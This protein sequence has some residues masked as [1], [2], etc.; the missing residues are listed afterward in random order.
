[1]NGWP[2]RALLP[3]T[4]LLALVVQQAWAVN[5]S[6]SNTQAL[7]FGKFAAGSGGSVV[8]NPSGARSATGGVVLISSSSGSAAQFTVTGD[9]N[10]TF[11]ITLPANGTVSLTNGSQ[12]MPLTSFTSSPGFTGQLNASGS[13]SISVGASLG[14]GG[15]QPTG[16]YSGAFD[17]LVE[18]N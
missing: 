10:L 18:Y 4:L 13:Q 11:A 8:V 15:S 2:G 1:M 3:A 16:S 14:V 7:G 12:T 17:V 9:A 6:I 5:I